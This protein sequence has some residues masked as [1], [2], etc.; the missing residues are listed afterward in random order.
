MWIQH[1]LVLLKCY[2]SQKICRVFL[3]QMS[4]F[5]FGSFFDGFRLVLDCPQLMKIVEY[6]PIEVHTCNC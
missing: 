2:G 3:E 6:H 4:N 1:Q 5:E